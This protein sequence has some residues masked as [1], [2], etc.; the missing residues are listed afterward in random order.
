VTP[1][2][3]REHEQTDGVESLVDKQQYHDTDEH[4]YRVPFNKWD[5]AREHPNNH[6]P[7]S[8]ED[9]GQ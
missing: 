2:N 6:Y 8:T 5:V 1:W 7:G 9:Q 3:V 4:C